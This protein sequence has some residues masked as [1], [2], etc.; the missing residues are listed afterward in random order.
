MHL[1]IVIFQKWENKG[2]LQTFVR[3]KKT[4]IWLWS[5]V[6]NFGLGILAWA[7]GDRAETFKPQ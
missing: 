4:L 3:S 1:N 7:L 5:A 2:V 6:N